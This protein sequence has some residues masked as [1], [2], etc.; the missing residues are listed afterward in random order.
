MAD[1]MGQWADKLEDD[2]RH[3]PVHYETSGGGRPYLLNADARRALQQPEAIA[4]NFEYGHIGDYL[5]NAAN[6]GKG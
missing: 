5:F 6:A 2:L 1:A 4:E 3:V